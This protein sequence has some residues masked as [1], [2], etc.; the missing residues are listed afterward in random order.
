MP[1]ARPLTIAIS[2]LSF[3]EKSRN[4]GMVA[5]YHFKV[6]DQKAGKNVVQPL[7]STAKRIAEIGCEVIIS[8]EK[9]V[10]PSLLDEHGRYNPQQSNAGNAPRA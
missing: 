9:R 10:D 1:L 5:V 2:R 6:W 8:S 7:K 3:A 4:I